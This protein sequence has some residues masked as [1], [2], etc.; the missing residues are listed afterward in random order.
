MRLCQCPHCESV[1]QVNIPDE[2]DYAAR[3]APEDDGLT[4]WVCYRC[5]QL[6]Y[7]DVEPGAKKPPDT[8]QP[9]EPIR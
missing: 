9:V 7:T 6:G 1:F 5:R 4:P 2:S 8:A 3:L